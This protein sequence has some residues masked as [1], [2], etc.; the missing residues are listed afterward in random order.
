VLP[1]TWSPSVELFTTADPPVTAPA[2]AAKPV[3]NTA[4]KR[5][6]SEVI[7]RDER[8]N[9]PNDAPNEAPWRGLNK[10]NR[11][12]RMPRK[13]VQVPGRVVG[14]PSQRSVINVQLQDAITQ[15]QAS[16]HGADTGAATG[17][18]VV[19]DTR[20]SGRARKPKRHN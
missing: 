2:A 15:Q 7:P 10:R 12:R 8:P 20:K 14:P 11:R 19:N 17:P 5:Q 3:A 13:E 18:G 9:A 6:I 1:L 4:H 16:A